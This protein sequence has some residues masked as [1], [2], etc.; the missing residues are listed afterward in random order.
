VRVMMSVPVREYASAAEMLSSIAAIRRGFFVTTP[1]PIV[2][3]AVEPE[4]E[5]EVAP[6]APVPKAVLPPFPIRPVANDNENIV[7]PRRITVA[8]VI[9]AV[10]AVWEV[11]PVHLLSHRRHLQVMRPRKVAYAL[12]CRLTT[13]SLPHIGRAMGNRDHTTVLSGCRKM[14]PILD[15]VDAR[16]GPEA[17]VLEWAQEMRKEM[18][19]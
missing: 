19:A 15:A 3:E 1:A 6:V 18:G 12:A 4:P 8:E 7:V 13:F 17:S 2:A 10:S 11:A 14:K 9:R 16:I 5:V